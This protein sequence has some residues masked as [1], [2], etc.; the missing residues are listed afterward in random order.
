MKTKI[1]VF[2]NK[3]SELEDNINKWIEKEDPTIRS[4][5]SSSSVGTSG[6]IYIT[7]II[8]YDNI[9]VID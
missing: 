9:E 3:F 7:V 6:Y 5:T 8:L 2:S 4:I 1:K